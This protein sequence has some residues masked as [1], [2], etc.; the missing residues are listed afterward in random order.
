MKLSLIAM[1][2]LPTLSFSE[3]SAIQ[4][5]HI[6]RGQLVMENQANLLKKA[7]NTMQP[8]LRGVTDDSQDLF[9][10]LKKLQA[11]LPT[12]TLRAGSDITVKGIPLDYEKFKAKLPVATF[13][14]KDSGEVSLTQEQGFEPVSYYTVEEDFVLTELELMN[15]HEQAVELVTASEKREIRP[16]FKY[17]FTSADPSIPTNVQ[18]PLRAMS[19]NGKVVRWTPGSKLKYCIR[20]STFNGD[21]ER[22]EDVKRRMQQACRDWEEKCNIQFEYMESLDSAQLGRV[23]PT[24]SQ[25]K[26]QV[27][28]VVA[29]YELGETIARAF[30]PNDFINKRMLLIDFDEYYSPSHKMDKTGILRHEIGHI[31]GFR[32]EHIADNAPTWSSDYCTQETSSGSIE[33]TAYDRA[34]VMHYPCERKLMEGPLKENLE[35]KITA[36]D[37][38][39]ARSIYGPSGGGEPTGNFGFRTFD[40]YN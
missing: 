30:F 39:G 6:D 7:L 25:G 37:E 31:L 34:S 19:E 22:Y 23:F 1:T 14:E 33:I 18:A 13:Y 3:E 24:D 35:L 11:S 20:K 15:Y 10:E 17:S 8:Q 29:Q 26:R 21:T 36:S 28:F 16:R 4:G 38:I 12:T 40:P 5:R 9:V 2:L 32:H 27:L